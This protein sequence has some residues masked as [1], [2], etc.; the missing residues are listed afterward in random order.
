MQPEAGRQPPATSTADAATAAKGAPD[1]SGQDAF[2]AALRGRGAVAGLCRGPG[3]D[4]S[5]RFDI[6]RN[7]VAV[8]LAEA[9]ETTFPAVGRLIGTTMLR[10]A[11]ADYAAANTP[12][13]PL[14]MRY[15]ATF[16][17]FLATLPGLR[18]YPAVPEAAAI[19]VARVS[20]YHAADAPPLRAEALAAVAPEAL[21]TLELRAHPAA[22]LVP[23]PH[24]G[25]AAWRANAA[26]PSAATPED[27]DA[28]AALVTRPEAD[29]LVHPLAAPAAHFAEALLAGRPLGEATAVEALDV[30]TALAALLA[31]GAF[32]G[33]RPG[34]QSAPAAN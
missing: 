9:I 14:M 4:G 26:R 5:A 28:A 11:A 1:V 16:P 17:A 27:K 32:A 24:G 30:A 22:R 7:N 21:Q 23:T 15:G 34:A 33:F 29:V 2:A 25:L 13:S 20:A 31:A 3:D 12:D 19:E 6:W 10:A 8:S 18:D